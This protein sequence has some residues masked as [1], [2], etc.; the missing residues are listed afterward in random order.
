MSKPTIVRIFY[1][2]VVAV[3]A[4][5]ILGFLA[6]WGAL[7][8]LPTGGLAA[9]G[10]IFPEPQIWLVSATLF[11]LWEMRSVRRQLQ[12]AHERSLFFIGGEEQQPAEVAT[13]NFDLKLRA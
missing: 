7:I 4:G 1:G 13:R 8:T 2:S 9:A 5:L 12:I 11:F 6:V 10:R 3:A